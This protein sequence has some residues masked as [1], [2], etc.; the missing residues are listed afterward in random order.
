[1][2][3][4]EPSQYLGNEAI[5]NHAYTDIHY[6]IREGQIENY[7]HFEA[8]VDHTFYKVL[9]TDPSNHPIILYHSMKYL[10]IKK[11]EL[12]KLCLKSSED[13]ATNYGSSVPSVNDRG[14]GW[15]M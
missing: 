7:D 13:V 3:E 14:S 10:A 5:A 11:N 12:Q 1:M 8:L 6:P 4:N 15:W 9:E 2:N